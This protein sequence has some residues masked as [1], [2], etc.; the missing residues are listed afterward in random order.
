MP[1][2]SNESAGDI[3]A[4]PCNIC[5]S[6]HLSALPCEN[7]GK[8]H[9]APRSSSPFAHKSAKNS[10]H[11]SLFALRTESSPSMRLLNERGPDA[12]ANIC[13]GNLP[14]PLP[15]RPEK[16]STLHDV[17]SCGKTMCT[18]VPCF[19]GGLARKES[20]QSPSRSSSV[21]N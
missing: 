19:A 3:P 2:A 5:S 16:Y 11:I 1:T 9:D 13:S 10:N 17:V 12:G 7:G 6:E 8:Q 14:F 4:Q 20:H 21:P 18:H 15:R